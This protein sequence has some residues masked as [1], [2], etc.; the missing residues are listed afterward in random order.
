MGVTE[1][2]ALQNIIGEETKQRV[3]DTLKYPVHRVIMKMLLEGYS[4]TEICDELDYSKGFVGQVKKKYLMPT[5]KEVL[6]IPDKKYKS[7]SNSG[8]IYVRS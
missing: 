7:L 1:D 4:Q 5:L 8:R 3:L 6:E 2:V